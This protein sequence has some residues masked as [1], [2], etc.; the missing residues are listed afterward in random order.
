MEPELD[1]GRLA[2]LEELL[3]RG[4]PE[5]AK[6]LAGELTQAM[7]GI[8]AGV[9]AGD[10]TAAALAGHE[11]RNSALMLNAEPMLDALREIEAAARVPDI[12]RA[13]LGLEELR[14]V[15][16]ALRT[17]LEAEAERAR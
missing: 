13:R 1:L 12:A 10:L 2:E 4:V 3:G 17:R 15:W 16:A 14:P 5:I 7:A 11:A 9:A 8:E 6:T